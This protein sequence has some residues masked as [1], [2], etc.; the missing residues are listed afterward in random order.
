MSE[1]VLSAIILRAT[2]FL[3]NNPI[4]F[5]TD[6]SLPL[7]DFL[8]QLFNGEFIFSYGILAICWITSRLFAHDFEEL[9]D[10]EEETSFEELGKI[11]N[12]LKVIRQRMVERV[13]IVGAILII[14]TM[15]TRLDLKGLFSESQVHWNTDIP[16][17]AV[18]LY[19][20]LS[21]ILFSYS[22]LSLLRTRWLWEKLPTSPQIARRWA[23]GSLV[24][25]ILLGIVVFFLPTQYSL[26]FLDTLN[27]I[28]NWVISI[29]T[30]MILLG[31]FLLAFLLSLL[32]MKD[33]AIEQQG[34]IPHPP[35][36]PEPVASSTIPW[37][38]A[39]KSIFF[40]VTLG[41]I[42]IFST[43]YFWRQNKK[44]VMSL[45]D[46]RLFFVF[47][48][49]ILI[50]KSWFRKGKSQ[51]DKLIQAGVK[52]LKLSRSVSILDPLLRNIN[53]MRLSSREKVIRAFIH[54]STAAES[55]GLSRRTN[56]PPAEYAESLLEKLPE[57]QNEV[58]EITNCFHEARYTR[59]PISEKNANSAIDAL[60]KVIGNL[61]EYHHRASNPP[62]SR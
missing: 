39:F 28:I 46:S 58:I 1:A 17:A 25:F 26:G 30:R 23:A 8:L 12:S 62:E 37:W 20:A 21:L 27:I 29:A 53:L 7:T 42:V 54:L 49:V 40:W 33:E 24:F 57:V 48:R 38:D 44:L 13:F 41:A 22:Q 11:T 6:I 2:I 51:V 47:S 9:E 5:L 59:H 43:I 15:I 4:Q 32:G 35:T 16:V 3:V 60:K 36:P 45:F 19:F 34:G 50:I 61:R 10:R 14:I 55:Q 56:Q 18:V 52:L 31:S